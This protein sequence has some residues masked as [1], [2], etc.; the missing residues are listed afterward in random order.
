M[1][2][3]EAQGENA[4]RECPWCSSAASSLSAHGIS[5]ELC[6]N[7]NN[8]DTNYAK[9]WIMEMPSPQNNLLHCTDITL[10]C[11]PSCQMFMETLLLAL[12]VTFPPVFAW[13]QSLH[14]PISNLYTE[15]CL[16]QIKTWRE[17]CHQLERTRL[18]WDFLSSFI[19][20]SIW[21]SSH[22]Y[23]KYLF[24]RSM[25]GHCTR[26]S[27]THCATPQLVVPRGCSIFKACCHLP[28]RK[29]QLYR[30]DCLQLCCFFFIVLVWNR[31]CKTQ[32][33]CA[34]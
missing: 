34:L 1:P 4:L 18:L 3:W 19:L 31:M 32:A 8:G 14:L 23:P 25:D 7:L 11:H 30:G 15:C 22:D 16:L 26:R 27:T 5:L 12:N 13:E 33:Q 17:L 21:S 24:F 9:T 6:R 10:R 29:I 28:S 2:L 20:A